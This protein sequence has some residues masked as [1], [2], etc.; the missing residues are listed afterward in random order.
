M[1]DIRHASRDRVLDRS[2]HNG[3]VSHSGVRLQSRLAAS[4][5]SLMRGDVGVRPRFALKGDTFAHRSRALAQA[6]EKKSHRHRHDAN[7]E[8]A[9]LAQRAG[10]RTLLAVPAAHRGL[11]K[12]DD[13]DSDRRSARARY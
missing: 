13:F 2:L 1:V 7:A 8:R 6:A 10:A 12:V 5:D 3:A 4:S 11:A 9:I